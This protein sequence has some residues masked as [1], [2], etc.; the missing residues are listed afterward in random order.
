M[1][2]TTKLGHLPLI[3]LGICAIAFLFLPA[4][5]LLTGCSV[6]RSTDDEF[7]RTLRE[8]RAA[9]ELAAAIG[10]RHGVKR[11]DIETLATELQKGVDSGALDATN[12]V[13]HAIASRAGIEGVDLLI[14]VDAVDLALSRTK[15]VPS[16]GM[17]MLSDRERT[18]FAV[19]VQAMRTGAAAPTS[20]PKAEA[21]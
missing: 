14:A 6:N 12:G 5:P 21:N 20:E 17:F 7:A 16:S 4:I 15:L 18:L 2:Y 13:L 1:K 9:T 10:V 11:E 3:V 19:I 8:A